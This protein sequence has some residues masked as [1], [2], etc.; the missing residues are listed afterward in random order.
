M[1]IEGFLPTCRPSPYILVRVVRATL[2]WPSE[3]AVPAL[4][5]RQ[6]ASSIEAFVAVQ[7]SLV[8]AQSTFLAMLTTVEQAARLGTRMTRCSTGMRRMAGG[9]GPRQ[10]PSRV[11]TNLRQAGG[12][13]P[14]GRPCTYK[15]PQKSASWLH[16]PWCISSQTPCR[17]DGARPPAADNEASVKPAK[18]PQARPC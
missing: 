5:G 6:A 17:G 12:S 18:Q 1:D 13:H 8:C 10:A 15:H 16:W 2:G 14:P 4:C 3:W 7:A 9:P 11:C